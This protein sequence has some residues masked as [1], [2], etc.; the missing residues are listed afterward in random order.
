MNY[1]EMIMIGIGGFSGAIIRYIVS[2][3]LNHGNRI[4]MGTLIVNLAG[5]FLIGCI[6][7]LELSRLWTLFFAAGLAGALTTF[8]T[9]T[10]ELIEQWQRGEKREA[11]Q[12]LLIT[13]IAG[14]LFTVIGYL[15]TKQT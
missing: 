6:F 1:L 3:Y 9:F 4:P 12:Y 11:A 2:K 15:I 14:L 10:K 8:S 5:S 13:Y 7:G